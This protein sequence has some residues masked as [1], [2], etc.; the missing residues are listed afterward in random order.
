M[1]R[2]PSAGKLIGILVAVAAV[3]LVVMSLAGV[4]SFCVPPASNPAPTN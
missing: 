2:G 3:F 1:A 4:P